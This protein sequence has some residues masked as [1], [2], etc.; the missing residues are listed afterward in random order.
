MAFETNRADNLSCG[1]LLQHFSHHMYG[2]WVEV[3][4]EG[5]S[6]KKWGLINGR[7]KQM[8]QEL[9][10][11]LYMHSWSLLGLYLSSIFLWLLLLLGTP[12][13]APGYHVAE[14]SDCRFY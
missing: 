11:F 10:P 3:L 12:G 4:G 14:T 9:R 7:G 8:D 1:T 5:L 13:E 6:T 2:V